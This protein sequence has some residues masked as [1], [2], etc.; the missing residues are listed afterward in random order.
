MEVE[1]LLIEGIMTLVDLLLL[2]LLLNRVNNTTA[3][4]I[5]TISNTNM[6]ITV[7]KGQ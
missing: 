7:H 2:L 1:W 5:I 4:A 3:T 6:T